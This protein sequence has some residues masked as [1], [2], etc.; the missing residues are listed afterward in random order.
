MW[1]RPVQHQT[2]LF[3]LRMT[4]FE[5]AR[6]VERGIPDEAAFTRVRGFV[7]GYWRSKSQEP[8]RRLGYAMDAAIAGQGTDPASLIARIEG[9]SRDD[10]NAAIRRHL[11]ADRLSW[12][13]V[14]EE[15][16]SLVEALRTKTPATMT[17]TGAVPP[18]VLEEDK[19]IGDL[20]LGFAEGDVLVLPPG[21]LFER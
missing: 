2:R 19:A 15:A 9:L 16:A 11:R 13:V 3:A 4:G 6:F 14:T 1:I 5:L 12:V 20:D 17:Y 21:A 7:A 10:V 18:F 8:M